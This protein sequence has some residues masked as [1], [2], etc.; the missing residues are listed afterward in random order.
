MRHG[1]YFFD[2][3]KYREEHA[4]RYVGFQLAGITLMAFILSDTPPGVQVPRM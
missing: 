4:N 3:A 2:R 1:D